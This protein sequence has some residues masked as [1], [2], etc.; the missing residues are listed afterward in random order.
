MIA[1]LARFEPGA[2]A[3]PEPDRPLAAAHAV[4]LIIERA[5]AEEEGGEL[6]LVATGPLTNV[7]AVIDPSLIH[8]QP[9]HVEIE[10]RGEHTA[11]RTVCDVY[12]VTGQP[13]NAE[14]AVGIDVERFWNLL[15][16]TLARYE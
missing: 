9:M 3:L 10:L 8:T 5:L 1:T 16:A 11:G 12:G 13:A 14:V 6:R 4:D 7:A 15:I 2:A